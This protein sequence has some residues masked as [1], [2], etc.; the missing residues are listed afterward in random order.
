VEAHTVLEHIRSLNNKEC[1][2]DL[3]FMIRKSQVSGIISDHQQN[4]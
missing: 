4:S 1:D 3:D 2:V